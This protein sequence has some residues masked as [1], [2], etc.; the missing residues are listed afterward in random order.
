[1]ALGAIPFVLRASELGFEQASVCNF[2]RTAGQKLFVVNIRNSYCHLLYLLKVN[3]TVCEQDPLLSS[4]KRIGVH[5]SSPK[6]PVT[7]RG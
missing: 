7:P 2:E 1:M 4:A 6:T 5:L 3:R